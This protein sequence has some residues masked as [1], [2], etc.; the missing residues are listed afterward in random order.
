MKKLEGIWSIELYGAFGWETD[1]VL[2][3]E[4][5]RVFGGGT[6]HYSKGVYS[7]SD[8]KLMMT[9]HLDYFGKPRTLFGERERQF[10]VEFTGER[11]QET[12]TGTMSRPD[13]PRFPLEFQLIKRAELPSHCYR[14]EPS[15]E[16]ERSET[17][18]TGTMKP[19]VGTPLP[20]A[21]PPSPPLAGADPGSWSDNESLRM[22]APITK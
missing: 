4:N 9:V 1:G 13:K 16:D 19:P 8:G 20:R 15:K 3:M 11:E 6:N 5:G 18:G 12:I 21:A 22:T 2:V 17:H 7:D 14:V 10:T